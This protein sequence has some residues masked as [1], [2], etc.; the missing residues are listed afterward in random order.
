MSEH[1]DTSPDTTPGHRYTADLAGS[2]ESRWQE[3]W[4]AEG[5]FDA[6]NPVGELSTGDPVPT[7]KLF[8]QDMFPYPSGSGL[9]VGHPLGYIATDVFARYH[10]MQGR[11][12]LH[13]LGYDAFGLPAEQY[14]VQT[15][16]HPRTTTEA[17]IANMRRQLGR[18]GLGHDTRRSL[19]TT[20]VDFYHWT[21][22]IFLQIFDSWYDT[23]SGKARPIAELEAEFASGERVLD[24][25]RSW[26]SLSVSERRDVLDGH[27]LVYESNSLVNWCPGLGTV[28]ANEEVTADGRS[29]RGNFPVF[30]KNLR[31]WMMRITA[32]SDRLID[33]LD[34]LD[35]PDKVKT[36]QRNWIGRSRGAEVT[37]EAGLPHG[38][39]TA[40]IDVF[41]TRP[42][43]LFG[44][45]YV[46]LA[47]E[48]PLVDDITAAAWPTDTDER[49]THGEG[50]PVL[51]VGAYRRAIAA[52]SDLERQENKEKTGVFTGAFAVNPVNGASVPVFIADYVLTGY[53][54]G[55][56]MAVPGHD[57]RDWE[58]ATKFGLPVV[59]VISGGDVDESAWTGDGELVNSGFLDGLDVDAAKARVIQ[60]LE[61][62][63]HGKGTIQY[64]L[65][66]WLFARQRYWGEPFPI[67]Y[68]ANGKA[69]PL[70]ETVLPVELPE[71]EDYA[72][73][74][75]DPDDANSEPSPPLAKATD[76]V[77]VELDLGDGLQTYTRDTNVM[78]QWA[79]SSWY[80]LRYI[81]PTNSEQMC[82]PENE[83]YWMGPRPDIHGEN[84][85]GGLDLYVGGVE[86]AVLHL[87]Y[88]RFWH[89]V[90]FDLGHVSSKEPY[91]RL[92]NQGYIQA[93]AFT[94]ARGVYVPADEVTEEGGKYFFQG[95]E[96][97]REYGKMG[98]SLKNSVSP[99]E[100]F[101]EYGA[102][103]LRMYEMSMGPLDT[104]RPWATK[105]VVGAQRFLQRVWRLVVDEETGAVRTTDAT[106]SDATLKALNRTVEGVDADYA[107]LRD[108]T[109]GAK[110][111]E[112]T[113][114]LTKEYPQGAP[115]D[116]VEPLVL[117]LA[118]LAPHIAEELWNTLGHSES[119]AHGPFPTVDEK[120]LVDDTVDYP[121]QVNGKVRS[122]ITVAADAS[123]EDVQAV[124]LADEKIV[125]LLDGKE[126]KKVIVV[127]G[128]MVNIVL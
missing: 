56:I 112:Y 8:V 117:M 5:T 119:L 91:R 95:A 127:P 109:A 60:Q 16:T 47:P 26:E 53:G 90:L 88:A 44:A 128:R 49:W 122:R 28:L 70:P 92:Y 48:H 29:D 113:N 25:G 14:A 79:G 50:T 100:I 81:D 42:D 38:S 85:P 24:D 32:Y 67:V 75:F 40:D 27:R 115:R 34:L 123:R 10:R 6:P 98:K 78:P 2:L 7:D 43:T 94:D 87:L 111:I 61:K 105:D 21:Q 126:P 20:D 46:V 110:L 30:R 77:N 1:G 15:G 17:N 73:V 118:P 121:I 116:A 101:A 104:S 58:F 22:W 69:H 82:A 65:R 89:K 99:D 108:N 51:A 55:A 71:V 37:F 63:G 120:W 107:A 106:P 35:W 72:P 12:V 84:D 86:H 11:N 76:W 45:T 41:T 54:T 13:T 57:Q 4:A 39:G 103:T 93:Y 19:A 23:E 114:H 125:A 64:K 66:D 80:Q 59:Q 97:N 83:A 9:H 124:A 3:R 36:M 18:L 33:D 102:D 52:K 74:S 68:D 62:D 96:V 31:Q